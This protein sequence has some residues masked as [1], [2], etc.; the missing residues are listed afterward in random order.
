LWYIY[1][2][3]I[4]SIFVSLQQVNPT[5]WT[6]CGWLRNRGFTRTGFI[7]G[8]CQVWFLQVRVRVDLV[9]PVGVPMTN[10]RCRR[11]RRGLSYPSFFR[12]KDRVRTEQAFKSVVLTHPVTGADCKS[13]LVSVPMNRPSLKS[14]RIRVHADKNCINAMCILYSFFWNELTDSLRRCSLPC[15]ITPPPRF[16]V[17]T[18]ST[19]M[20]CL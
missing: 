15:I 10:L 5:G 13:S 7:P 20:C 2:H 8:P 4:H 9:V 17:H 18:P 1:Y 3:K 19:N 14:S 6:T 16:C 12:R 11:T